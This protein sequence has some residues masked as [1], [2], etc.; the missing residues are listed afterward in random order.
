M[1]LAAALAATLMAGQSW[2]QTQTVTTPGMYTDRSDD[3]CG[4][5]G[6]LRNLLVFSSSGNAATATNPFRIRP[7]IQCD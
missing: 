5:F 1:T 2:G 4:S 6:P 7:A 3:I